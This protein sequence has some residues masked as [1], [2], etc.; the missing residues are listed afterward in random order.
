MPTIVQALDKLLHALEL[1][2]KERSEVAHEG[3]RLGEALRQHLGGG[4]QHFLAGSYSRGVAI[5]PLLDIPLFL[6]LDEKTHAPLREAGPAA[7]LEAVERAVAKAHP[8]SPPPPREGR[9]VNVKPPRAGVGFDVVPAFAAGG[10][11][12]LIPDRQQQGWIKTNPEAAKEVSTN[13]NE[14]AG[15]KLHPLIRAA[16]HWNLLHGKP[17][18]AFHLEAM[19]ARAV[20]TPPLNYLDAL[21]K[22]FAKVSEHVLRSC[23]DP[24]GVGPNI[25]DDLERDRRTR[26]QLALMEA[27]R[28]VDQALQFDRSWRVDEAHGVFRRLFG[29]AYPETGR[30]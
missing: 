21:R 2:E 13:T 20:P 19:A 27:L 25:D 29:E 16:K 26:A 12:Y 24:A 7:C 6:V 10:G 17:L 11:V 1:T 3:K 30:R 4:T 5:R 18:S 28:Q 9:A 8:D 23:P 14:K 22:L 15:A